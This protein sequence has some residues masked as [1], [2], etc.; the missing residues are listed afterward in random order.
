MSDRQPLSPVTSPPKRAAAS[1]TLM[2]ALRKKRAVAKLP[3]L[4]R[5][6]YKGKEKGYTE[7]TIAQDVA[8]LEGV[9]HLKPLAPGTLVLHADAETRFTA[10]VQIAHPIDWHMYMPSDNSKGKGKGVRKE[11]SS[12]ELGGGLCSLFDQRWLSNIHVPS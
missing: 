9:K 10:W 3:A 12:G 7:E 1:D 5:F 2:A 4:D 8:E 6:I 11:L